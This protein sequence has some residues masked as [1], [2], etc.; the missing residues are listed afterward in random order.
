[1]LYSPT[2][3]P[4]LQPLYADE[5]L[6]PEDATSITAKPNRWALVQGRVQNLTI[7]KN[8]SYLNFGDDWKSDF[9][10]YLPKATLKAFAPEALQALQ[11]KTIQVR[12]WLHSYYGPRITLFN[13]DMLKLLP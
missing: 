13:P 7:L 4:D 9:T 6:T 8:A 11:G 1:M 10:I 12:G 5:S 3:L 2:P